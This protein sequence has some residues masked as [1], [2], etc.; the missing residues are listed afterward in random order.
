MTICYFGIYKS[1]FSRNKIYISGLKK[2]DIKVLECRDDSRGLLKY[3][4]L[5]KKHWSIRN[6]YDVIIVGY[7]GHLVV[8]LAKILS[9]KLVIADLLGSLEDAEVNSHHSSFIRP[10]KSKII[11]WF[12]V[13]CADIV[14]LESESQKQFFVQKF[15]G[16]PEK[17][18][19]LH[20]GAD[21]RTFSTIIPIQKLPIFTV[22]FRGSLTPEAGLSYIL[23]AAKILQN[24]S[25]RFRIMGR[26][27]G[28]LGVKKQIKDLDL[29]NVE[30]MTEKLSEL[31]LVKKMSECHISLGQFGKN[32]RLARTI[33]HKAF[34]SLA[35]VLPYVTARADGISSI[36]KDGESCLMV[37]PADA[38]D[39]ARA[40]SRLK[41]DQNLSNF[42]SKNGQQLFRENFTP[43]KLTQ[44]FIQIV[45][46]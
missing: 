34:E 6:K 8:P 41:N 12:A 35:L 20:T 3:W 30:L 43:T 4:R 17:F 28:E 19:V 5:F 10:L 37:N 18:K 13:K 7:P 2:N 24:E 29:W 21:D 15:G 26:G 16:D 46:K 36:L 11:D 1:D 39:M 14:L 42:L 27:I 38:D 31:D 44:V 33:P 40:I 9:K 25:I 23:E 32:E 22:L 45:Q